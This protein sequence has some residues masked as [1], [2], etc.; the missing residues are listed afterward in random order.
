MKRY[1]TIFA[2]VKRLLFTPA[3][4]WKVIA[5]EK[6]SVSEIFFNFLLPFSIITIVACYIGYGI[7]GSKQDMFGLIASEKLG[8]RYAFYYALLL[9]GSIYIS[10]FVFSFMAPFFQTNRNF[11][12]NFS[13]IVYSFTPSMCATILLIIPAFSPIVLIAGIYN[14][15]LLYVGLDRMTNVQKSKKWGYFGTAVGVLVF[16]FFAVSKILYRIIID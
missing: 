7:V 10:A 9:I 1:T 13:L 16:V 8:F 5:E 3:R 4:E 2:R 12:S 11:N 15:L 14:L 6:R